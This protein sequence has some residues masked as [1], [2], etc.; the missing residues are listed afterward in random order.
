MSNRETEVRPGKD[1]DAL[2]F[3]IN[4]LALYGL[5]FT[6]IAVVPSVAFW[7]VSVARG[8]TAFVLALITFHQTQIA[9]YMAL[10]TLCFNQ[11]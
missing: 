4:A 1:Y 5:A 9:N 6:L 11:F 7:Q 10:K 3:P 2:E 8:Q